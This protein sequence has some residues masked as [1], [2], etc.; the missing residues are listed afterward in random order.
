M[1]TTMT[2]VVYRWRCLECPE[3]GTG[4]QSE[5]QKAAERHVVKPP[6]HGTV[7]KGVAK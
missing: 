4:T 3:H 2:K 1:T 6:K 7:A 5:V